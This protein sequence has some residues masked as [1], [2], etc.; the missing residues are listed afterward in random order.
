MRT[1]PDIRHP[2]SLFRPCRFSGT[3]RLSPAIS[4]SYNRQMAVVEIESLAKSY[5]V[6]H[7]AEGLTASLAGL[8]HRRYRDVQAVRGINLTVEA[9]E[10]V[11]SSVPTGRQ[12]DDTLPFRCDQSDFRHGS[13]VGVC[14]PCAAKTRIG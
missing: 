6:Y 2:A 13:R 4:G 1:P 8:F 10:F 12:N 14:M 3:S 5:R 7:K 9:G 11:A